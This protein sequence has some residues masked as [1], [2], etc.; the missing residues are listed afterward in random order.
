[1]ARRQT[2]EEA[3]RNEVYN[4]ALLTLIEQHVDDPRIERCKKHPLV[5][6]L[7]IALCAVIC[8]ARS[9][10]AM[11]EFGKARREWLSKILDLRNGIPSHDTFARV[12][13]M[14]CPDQVFNPAYSRCR[15]AL[16]PHS[17]Y[18]Q[19]SMSRLANAEDVRD[20]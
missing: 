12:L 16:C 9:F 13:S 18:D 3:F 11:E 5:N 19:R 8:G 4:A 6:V 1:M 15:V 17:L 20:G 10:V 7:F 2:K 14:L